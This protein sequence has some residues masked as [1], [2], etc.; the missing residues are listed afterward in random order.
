MIEI[1]RHSRDTLINSF[2]CSRRLAT[3]IGALMGRHISIS[4]MLLEEATPGSDIEKLLLKKEL[5]ECEDAE[6]ALNELLQQA[7]P[8]LA[9]D[10]PL[11][12]IEQDGFKVIIAEEEKLAENGWSEIDEINPPATTPAMQPQ[13][14]P[15]APARQNDSAVG[16]NAFTPDEIA[17]LRVNIFAGA[18]SAEKVAAL[19]QL[20]FTNLPD[21]EKASILYQALADEDSALRSAATGGLRKMG[22]EASVCDTAR[23]LAE[24][25]ETERISAIDRLRDLVSTA[26]DSGKDAILMSFMGVLRDQSQT[27]ATVSELLKAISAKAPAF[28]PERIANEDITRL[29]L[30]LMLSAEK[31]MLSEIRGTL[32]AMNSVKKGGVASFLSKEILS[33]QSHEYRGL[34]LEALT[35]MELPEEMSDKLMEPAGETMI[36]LPCS[37][38]ACQSIGMF[39]TRSG[40][41]GAVLLAEKLITCDTAHQRHIIRL[42]DN[43]MR[44]FDYS[45]ETK[46]IIAEKAL[47]VLSSSPKQVRA[48][49]IETRIAAR[50]DTPFEI[51]KQLAEAFLRDLREYAHWPL[52]DTMEAS[53]VQ[54]G[55]AA[56]EPLVTSLKEYKN[57]PIAAII[58]SALGK[59][60]MEVAATDG[61]QAESIL[62]ELQTLTFND[63]SCRDMLHL[64][65]GRICSQ[66]LVSERVGNIIQRSLLGRLTGEATDAATI[67][68][69]GMLCNGSGASEDE[70]KTVAAIATQHLNIKQ[71]D[72]GIQMGQID[73]EEV[74]MLGDELTIYSELIPSCIRTIEHICL[75]NPTPEKLRAEL[76]ENLIETWKKAI[77]FESQWSPA[78]VTQ[79]TECIGKIGASHIISLTMRVRIANTLA[80]RPG[81]VSVLE[82]L[83]EILARGDESP[84]LDRLGGGLVLRLLKIIEES[85]GLKVEDREVYLAILAKIAH[86]GS[87]EIRGGGTDR[88]LTR[89]LNALFSGLSSGIPGCLNHIVALR[90]ANSLPPE[91]QKRLENDLAGFTSL[92]VSQNNR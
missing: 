27:T 91:L 69:L 8:Q 67:E 68:A 23:M 32:K 25:N 6:P 48:D 80:Q 64:A 70:I 76:I 1:V 19:R 9:E 24:G 18:S 2:G 49:I 4:A 16:G 90:K 28:G 88:L 37:D 53:L 45:E 78:N 10:F 77:T 35:G 85:E 15:V 71:P 58:A 61:T 52:S 7:F 56:I 22:V 17:R 11:C 59:I 3:R 66:P 47:P 14:N 21:N 63:I 60:G 72:P 82:A 42:L 55:D 5:L 65:M 29:L 12:V 44:S 57:S 13:A 84:Q 33:S 79:L 54:L 86:R 36:N 39:L 87:F 30:E 46:T 40:E 41:R 34:M 62:R 43:T 51:R 81:E 75:G 92:K 73:G 20:T 50:K 31:Q 26:H 89:L 74:F 83:A 38:S